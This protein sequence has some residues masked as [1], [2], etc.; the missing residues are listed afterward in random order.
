MTSGFQDLFLAFL[1]A[2]TLVYMIM[3]SQFEHLLHPLVIMF[4]V[5]MAFIGVIA[6]L[7]AAGSPVNVIVFMGLIILAGVAVNNGIVMI[8]YINQKRKAGEDAY[9]AVVEERS[10]G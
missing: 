10:P 9:Q 1:I 6:A 8:D 5:P 2:V 4:T 3:A 7:A